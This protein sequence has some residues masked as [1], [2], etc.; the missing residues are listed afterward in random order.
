MTEEYEYER[1][2]IKP[3]SFELFRAEVMPVLKHYS[4]DDCMPVAI[5]CGVGKTHVLLV[6]RS[7]LDITF[8]LKDYDFYIRKP[9]RKM[10]KIAQYLYKK[11]LK[12]AVKIIK[13]KV[14]TCPVTC[15]CGAVEWLEKNG[16]YNN[17]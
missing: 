13:I 9:K 16:F 5:I 11:T 15:K 12:E 4:P 17:Y 1:V 7:G 8:S 2:E 10:V 3:E 14:N 6:G